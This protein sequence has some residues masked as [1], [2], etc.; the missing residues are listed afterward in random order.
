MPLNDSNSQ[1]ERHRRTDCSHHITAILWQGDRCTFNSSAWRSSA[2]IGHGIP[3]TKEQGG[4]LKALGLASHGRAEAWLD[5]E[6]TGPQVTSKGKPPLDLQG[7]GRWRQ[8][9]LTIK[10]NRKSKA[11]QMQPVWMWVTPGTVT[12]V[13]GFSEGTCERTFL[14][15]S[16]YFQTRCLSRL[17]MFDRILTWGVSLWHSWT[18]QL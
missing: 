15:R 17:C 16:I 11:R 13:M 9:K 3:S 4:S 18:W 5:E 10:C 12:H 6:S 14:L 7:D 1:T 2:G 8:K